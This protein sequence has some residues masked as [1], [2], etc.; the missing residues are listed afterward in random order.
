MLIFGSPFVASLKLWVTL[1]AGGS[2]DVGRDSNAS[3]S[4]T[5]YVYIHVYESIY[6]QISM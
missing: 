4:T 5:K 3:T 6:A 1:L 2:N